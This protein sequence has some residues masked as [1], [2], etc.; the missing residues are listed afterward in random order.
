MHGHMNVNKKV[1]NSLA[2]RYDKRL[3]SLPRPNVTEVG[4]LPAAFLCQATPHIK[5]APP[6]PQKKKASSEN[7]FLLFSVDFDVLMNE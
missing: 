4:V 7:D 5:F 2:S 6:P 3:F 1:F